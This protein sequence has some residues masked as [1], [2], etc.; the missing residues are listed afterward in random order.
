[1]N[2]TPKFVFV[3]LGS[4]IPKYAQ[5]N[6]RLIRKNFPGVE[7]Y[8]ISDNPANR[9]VVEGISFFEVPSFCT[10]W[11]EIQQSISH[12]LS[13]RNGFWFTSIARFKAIR[14]LMATEIDG[15]IIHLELDVFLFPDFPLSLFTTISEELA[16]TIASPTEGSAAILYIK[17][18]SAINK[19]VAI[20]ENICRNSSHSTDMTVL[21]EIVDKQLIST[22]ILPSSTSE[23]LDIES[24]WMNFVFDPS[25]WGMYLLGQDPR[26]HRGRLIFCR[27]EKHHFIQ[28]NNFNLLF[29]SGKLFVEVAP[30]R[31]QIANLHVHSKDVRVFCTPERYI[32]YRTK[33][34]GNQE[35]SEFVFTVFL[36]LFAKKIRKEVTLLLHKRRLK[37]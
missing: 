9:N 20:S 35:Y 34:S 5:I 29:Q 31:A 28:P 37:P 30:N 8:L 6:L 24:K 13:F 16:F 17:D 26:N 18:L 4:K 27:S 14:E 1:M 3:F 33:R 23:S 10:F 36:R 32:A 25:S 11:P 22:F 12:D 21:K 19:L 2:K 15:P 7:I